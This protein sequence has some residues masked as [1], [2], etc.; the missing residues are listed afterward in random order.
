[1]MRK[2]SFLGFCLPFVFLCVSFMAFSGVLAGRPTAI[3]V[4]KKTNSLHLCEYQDGKYQVLKTFHTTLG[5]VKG[6]K[7]EENDL[8]TP[9]GIYLFNS[10]AV[11]PVLPKKFGS[12]GVHLNFPNPYDVLA[13]R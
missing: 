1:M 3:L 4:D 12:L 5:R 2:F 13:G 11:P 10:L 8:K 7:E 6:D 9:E